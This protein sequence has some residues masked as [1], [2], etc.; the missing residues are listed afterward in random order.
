[1]RR[2]GFAAALAVGL[3]AG[4]SEA[5]AQAPASQGITPQAML[6]LKP[7]Q[8]IGV[9]YETPTGQAA[10]DACKVETLTEQGRVTGYLL[11]D[12]QGK[13]LR[14]FLSTKGG[15]GL[16]QWSYYQDGFEVYRDLDLDGDRRADEVRWLNAGGTR[17]GTVRD[18]KIVGWKRISA[19]EASKVLVQALAAG[20]LGLVES[21]VATPEELAS[22][23]IPK[24]VI[25]K[26]AG[27]PEKRT[28][29]I[30]ALT[31]AVKAS[32]EKAA[33]NKFDGTHPH[34]LPADPAAGLAK[35]VVLYE[36][37]MIFVSPPTPPGGQPSK[38]TML[39][40]PEMVQLGDTW[41]FVDLPR[42]V[43]PEKAVVASAAGIRS[44]LYE[45]GDAPGAGTHDEAM[46]AALKALAEF[47]KANADALA[48][49]G[50][51]R[52]SAAVHL[53]R[54]PLLKGVAAAA[55]DADEKLNYEKQAVDS[56]VTAYQTGA[57]S[58]GRETIE[59][60]VK[61]G[62]SLGSYASYRL[63][64]ADFVLRNEEPNSNFVANQKK[65]MTDLEGFLKEFPAS[66]E[67]PEVWLQLGS[68]NEFNAEEDKA[69]EDYKKL[70]A[71]FPETPAG[72]KAAGALKRL[73]LEGKSVTI[74]GAGADGSAIDTATL[75]GKPVLVVFW[76]S[77]GGQTVNRELPD[78][79]KLVEK[80]ASKGLQVVGVCLDNDKAQLEAF[81]KEHNLGWPQVFEPNGIDGRL[82][83][84]YG[85]ISLP[86]I[87]LVDAQGKVVN[88]NLR[89][90]SEVERQLEKVLTASKP[91]AVAA[92]VK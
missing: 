57:W 56:L 70:V 64:G 42:V 58:K 61:A 90:A 91:Q 18:N 24:E 43:D 12:G 9:E 34:A 40:V 1:M 65:W 63:I 44:A 28:D 37:A 15:K 49:A 10:I 27:A 67:A 60:L 73:D 22:A 7:A 21:V 69:R 47:D 5:R 30:A 86:T 39:Q 51:R 45:V 13:V 75:A 89:S 41:K 66:D 19:E 81:Q 55:K 4:A 33:W 23:G 92:G 80:N 85:I 50:E 17:I 87:F 16:D 2:L 53:K 31:A 20:D 84:E 68:S 74:A 14:R 46:E 72:K 35:D 36:N 26:V 6:G 82:A 3:G 79:A 71:D 78:I 77:W 11:R 88:R 38:L 48:G 59:G 76:A 54:V 29:Q 32:G 8:S 52:E 83:V 25:A 62:G